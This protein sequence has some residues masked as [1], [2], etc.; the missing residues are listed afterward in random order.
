MTSG[1]ELR[2]MNVT[3]VEYSLSGDIVEGIAEV[4]LK[5]VKI[6]SIPMIIISTGCN[7]WMIVSASPGQVTP[8]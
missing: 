5:N 3:L 4:Y 7:K 8:K 1:E 2:K 6:I